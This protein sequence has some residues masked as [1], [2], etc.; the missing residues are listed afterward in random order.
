MLT[1]K[2]WAGAHGRL[3][4]DIKR[5]FLINKGSSIWI[6]E[7]VSSISSL[8]KVVEQIILGAIT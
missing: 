4:K 8:G 5:S 3:C 6:S 2:H 1:N 7:S